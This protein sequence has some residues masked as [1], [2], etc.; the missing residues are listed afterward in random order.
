[1][2]D[3]QYLVSPLPEHPNE[4]ARWPRPVDRT[5]QLPVRRLPSPQLG[6]QP[7]GQRMMCCPPAFALLATT[8][9]ISVARKA[10]IVIEFR[11]FPPSSPS[12]RAASDWKLLEVMI[13]FGGV[14]G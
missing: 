10:L 5:Q 7:F 6:R 1:M 9:F 8:S 3:W 12:Q 4:A 13:T 14:R 2:P 11:A